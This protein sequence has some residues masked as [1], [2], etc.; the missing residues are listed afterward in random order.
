MSK[1][2]RSK[3]LTNSDRLDNSEVDQSHIQLR[4]EMN[5]EI[6]TFPADGFNFDEVTT[7]L[8][9]LINETMQVIDLDKQPRLPQCER[10]DDET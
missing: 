7:G 8:S 10:R 9:I 2:S 1:N 5:H 3:K 4:N 6:Y